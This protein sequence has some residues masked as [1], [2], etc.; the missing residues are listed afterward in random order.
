MSLIPAVEIDR[1]RWVDTH[2]VLIFFLVTT[3]F[4]EEQRVSPS[5]ET[6]LLAGTND[7][8]AMD[9]PG[10]NP[11]HSRWTNIMISSLISRVSASIL[12]VGGLILLFVP[13]VVLPRFVS[14]FPEA[15]LWLGQLLGASWLAVAALNWLSRSALLGGIYSRPIV[16]TNAT[17]YFVGAMVVLRAASRSPGATV[18]WVLVVATAIPASAYGWLLFR[19]PVE[20]DIQKQ[21]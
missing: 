5:D 6:A 1:F 11:I 3:V 13:D 15:G 19:G 7:G 2:P 4:D 10:T 8:I 9:I 16:F 12:L 20:A 17:L 14:D 18:L 21:R